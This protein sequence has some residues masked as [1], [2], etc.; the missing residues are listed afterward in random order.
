MKLDS[1]LNSPPAWLPV[2]NETGG[3]VVGTIV[4]MVRNLPGFPFPGWSTRESRAAVAAKLIPAIKSVRGYKTSFSAEMNT[5]SYGKRRAML[6]RKLLT[7]C[8]AARQDGC[9]VIIPSR[10][11]MIL[12]VNEEEHF[13]VHAFNDGF[14]INR[15][16][17]DVL[18][19]DEQ[20]QEHV[21]IA[22]DFQNGYLTSIPAEAGDGLQFYVLLHLPA[23]TFANMMGQITK[24]LEKLHV[25][26]SSYFSDGQD[27]TGH[28]YVIFSIP[29]P[30]DSI[31]QMQDG[32]ETVVRHLVMREMQ[33]RT[34]LLKD[35]GLNLLDAI[36][37][38]Y[39]LLMCC[40][41]L[42]I[43]ELRDSISFLRL[44]TLLGVISWEED[45]Q[46]VLIELYHFSLAM[47]TQTALAEDTPGSDL[48]TARALAAR[49]FLD[50]HPHTFSYNQA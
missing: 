5:L 36:A 21:D 43:K 25:N 27:D 26:V 32:F 45:E 29:G 30:E 2:R 28:L 22:Y 14:D 7:P 34:K 48:N 18:Q 50:K 42:S 46:S 23:L 11:N 38:A 49:D 39:G 1:I 20:L 6:T 16:L 19:L 44:G 9:H 33:V 3:I 17:K 12:M 41:R 8:M 24:A 31:E 13:V 37:R 15:S 47:A 35:P 10:R 4:R 40:R